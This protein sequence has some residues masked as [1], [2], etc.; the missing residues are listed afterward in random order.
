MERSASFVSSRGILKSC[1]RRNEVPRSS[2]PE[3]DFDFLE[4]AQDGETFYVCPEALPSFFSKIYPKIN[5][6][7]TLVTGDSDVS[8]TDALLGHPAFLHLLDNPLLDS[9]YAQNLFLTSRATIL[10]GAK[11]HALPIG[12]DYH[13][14][15]ESPGFWG[16]SRQSPIAQEFALLSVLRDAKPFRDRLAVGYC[17]FHLSSPRGDRKQCLEQIEHR[18]CLFETVR[19]PR[20]F[21]W[22]RQAQCMFVLS[23]EG[24]G[25]DCHRTWEALLLGCIPVLR[26]SPFTNIFEGLP[27]ALLD[28]WTDFT[29]AFIE[30]ELRKHLSERKY[31]FSKLYLAY[32]RHKIRKGGGFSIPEMTLNEFREFNVGSSF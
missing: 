14:M 3:L 26:R 19:I 24:I 23:P 11:I 17:N 22:I 20:L 6:R 10:N 32:W 13:T 21:S 18:A 29:E 4:N 27:V 31:D 15:W 8:I 2:S 28:S 1:N 25:L 9:W 5:S 16:H 7:F 30:S 12:M